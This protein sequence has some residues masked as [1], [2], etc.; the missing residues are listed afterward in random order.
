MQLNM[1]PTIA[2]DIGNLE[3]LVYNLFDPPLERNTPNYNSFAITNMLDSSNNALDN[4]ARDSM[5]GRAQEDRMPDI[6]FTDPIFDQPLLSTFS[7]LNIPQQAMMGFGMSTA[8]PILDAT[9]Q[10][11]VEQ[12]GF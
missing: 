2:H 5:Q 12:L 3:S 6:Q 1:H 9:W 10:S 8:P 11:F 7:N 4:T